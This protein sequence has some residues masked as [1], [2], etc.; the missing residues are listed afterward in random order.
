MKPISLLLLLL[1]FSIWGFAQTY[2]PLSLSKRIFSRDTMPDLSKYSTDEY[3]GH[4]NGTDLPSYFT[5]SFELLGQTAN[6]AVVC[7][8][9]TDTTGNVLNAYLHFKHETVWKLAAF[10]A[11]AMTGIIQ[12]VN[13]ELKAMKPAQIDS[14]IASKPVDGVDQRIF[15]S[16]EEYQFVLDNSSLTL[17]SDDKLVAHFN[18]HRQLFEQ[19]KDELLANN[20]A[21][22]F[23]KDVKTKA[24]GMKPRIN[25]LLISNVTAKGDTRCTGLDFLIGGITDNSVGYLYFKNEKDVPEM[26]PGEYIMIR[27]LGNGWYLYKTT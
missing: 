14:I 21:S 8:A 25:A 17:A 5:P 22:A 20:N 24:D 3:Q 6:T 4:P 26:S 23:E 2:D 9:I 10:R 13:A 12:Q 18:H 11:L 7:M 27:K 19:L 16:K 15:K 1:L